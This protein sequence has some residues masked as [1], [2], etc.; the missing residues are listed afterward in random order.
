M[1][2]GRGPDRAR[3][4][5]TSPG[6]AIASFP[7]PSAE[8]ASARLE[9]APVPT[10][11]PDG[12]GLEPRVP[13]AGTGGWARS[14]SPGTK[15]GRALQPREASLAHRLLGHMLWGSNKVP[16]LTS[17]GRYRHCCPG[18]GASF[19]TRP[20]WRH[21]AR[22][23]LAPRRPRDSRR[24][25]GK[26]SSVRIQGQLG[27]WDVSPPGLQCPQ[28]TARWKAP[29]PRGCLENVVFT[30]GGVHGAVLGRVLLRAHF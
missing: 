28:C 22:K 23:C 12:P 5:P 27:R 14:G 9:R 3:P 2:P 25:E 6:P 19:P 13:S 26:C 20:S 24:E 30:P 17:L 11:I 18:Q 7:E 29:P 21:S 15:A 16:Y 1:R 10:R 4:R 8:A